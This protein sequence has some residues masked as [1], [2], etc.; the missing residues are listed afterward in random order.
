M[1]EFYPYLPGGAFFGLTIGV[2]V[3]AII[4]LA[5]VLQL[6]GFHVYLTRHGLTTYDYIVNRA[7]GQGQGGHAGGASKRASSSRGKSSRGS[8]GVPSPSHASG[9]QQQQL[10]PVQGAGIGAAAAAPSPVC[11]DA[12]VPVPQFE[13]VSPAGAAGD[14]HAGSQSAAAVVIGGDETDVERA[15]TEASQVEEVEVTV[16]TVAISTS[17]AEAQLQ[18][19]ADDGP[20][21]EV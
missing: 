16:E 21:G 3:L 8:R 1:R 5:L 6:L 17:A 7:T 15:A 11:D 12:G 9:Q 20:T 2:T 18:P 14:L 13:P 19:E 10:A 4:A